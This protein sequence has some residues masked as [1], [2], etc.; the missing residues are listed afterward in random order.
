MTMQRHRCLCSLIF[1]F[2]VVRSR[3]KIFESMFMFQFQTSINVQIW[4]LLGQKMM[5]FS[6]KN[7]KKKKRSENTACNRASNK[8]HRRFVPTL[9]P[10]KWLFSN[11]SIR[12]EKKSNVWIVLNFS[13]YLAWNVI[14]VLLSK[15][16]F[17]YKTNNIQIE[18]RKNS[19]N[20]S[21]TNL[22]CGNPLLFNWIKLKSIKQICR[23]SAYAVFGK[24]S[25][26]KT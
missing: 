18:E 15:K 16:W 3:P 22:Y 11:R 20:N 25:Q 23:R 19:V 24:A 17:S 2:V 26:T 4:H 12:M 5:L 8:S 21:A 14:R 10:P 7:S 13:N 6:V 9:C 1:I